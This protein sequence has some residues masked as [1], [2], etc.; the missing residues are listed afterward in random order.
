MAELETDGDDSATPPVK[1]VSISHVSITEIQD[2]E[3][4]T[5]E[6]RNSTAGDEQSAHATI[7]SMR[8]RLTRS[9]VDFPKGL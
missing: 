2:D 4:T 9:K 8:T 1:T 7:A 3:T 5:E 6:A